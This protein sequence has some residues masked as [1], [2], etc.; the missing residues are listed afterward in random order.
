M[1]QFSGYFCNGGGGVGWG[2]VAGLAEV[3]VNEIKLT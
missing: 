2:A 3:D 1:R